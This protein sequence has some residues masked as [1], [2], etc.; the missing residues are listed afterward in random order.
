MKKVITLTLK[1]GAS[2][3]LYAYIFRKVDI[4]HLWLTIKEAR[5]SYVIWAILIYFVVQ[6]LSAY[7][8]Y[9]LLKPLG[10]KV[11][12]AKVLAIYFVGMYS[13]LFL[14]GAAIGGDV[15]R[16]YYLNKEVRNLSG[17]TATVFLDRDFGLGALLMIST[18]AAFAAG[19]GFSGVP[20]GPLFAAMLLGFSAINVALFYRP[21]YN[22][23]H[24]LLRLLRLKR[25]DE[26]VERLFQSVNSYRGDYGVITAASVLSVLIQFG[27]IIVN[28]VAGAGIG[29]HTHSGVVDYLVFIPAISLIGMNPLGING[30][31][32]REWAYI[33]LFTSAGAQKPAAVALALLWLAVL[34]I[35]SLPGGIIY[36]MQGAGK[37]RPDP[38][39]VNPD[40]RTDAVSS[41]L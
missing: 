17:A 1:I 34:V 25:S 21:T 5:A 9:V 28:I 15:V 41:D 33:I 37:A 27:G 23:F 31:G 35:T 26:K 4:A 11:P 7:R 32:W 2:V 30:M 29:I 6:G 24:K 10:I 38:Q 8:W 20:L 16:I 13:N 18:A 14:P 3:G 12:F 39:P 40:L 19:I 22:L 36:I